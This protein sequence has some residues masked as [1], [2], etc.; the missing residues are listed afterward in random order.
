[1]R[2][3]ALVQ[4]LDGTIAVDEDLAELGDAANN[5]RVAII[6]I[7]V[8]GEGPESHRRDDPVEKGGFLSDDE[9]RSCRDPG[10]GCW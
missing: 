1:M 4:T 7:V 9:A 5:A 6:V 10:N 8:V 2:E 3:V